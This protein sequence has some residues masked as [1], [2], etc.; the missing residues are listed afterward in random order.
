MI[1]ERVHPLHRLL[2]VGAVQEAEIPQ[3]LDKIRPS[4]QLFVV[5]C[6]WVCQRGGDRRGQRRG[7]SR[8]RCLHRTFPRRPR[9]LDGLSMEGI[10]KKHLPQ[11][12]LVLDVRECKGA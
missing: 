2:R 12:P 10:K 6:V 4:E 7:V 8:G 9:E 11:H 5:P 3:Q 1:Q